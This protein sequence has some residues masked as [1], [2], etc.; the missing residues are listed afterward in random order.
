MWPQSVPDTKLEQEITDKEK[1]ELEAVRA[2]LTDKD[3][4]RLIEETQTLKARQLAEDP[5]EKL[6]LIPSLTMKDLDHQVG[7][8]TQLH[9]LRC[10]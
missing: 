8:L 6:A 2:K 3:L 5:P 1:A 10:L 4:E 7:R 9:L